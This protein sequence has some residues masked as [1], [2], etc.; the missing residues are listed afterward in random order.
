VIQV[1]TGLTS[2]FSPFRL[3]PD[4]SK[5]LDHLLE[6]IALDW[7]F[8]SLDLAVFKLN[9]IYKPGLVFGGRVKSYREHFSFPP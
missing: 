5:Q 1:F 7:H 3:D 4:K 6:D 8:W 2:C 9:A